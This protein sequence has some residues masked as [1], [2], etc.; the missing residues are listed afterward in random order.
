MCK[1]KKGNQPERELAA[2]AKRAA[3]DTILYVEYFEAQFT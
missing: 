2:L 1:G 3:W